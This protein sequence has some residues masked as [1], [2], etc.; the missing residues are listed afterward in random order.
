MLVHVTLWTDEAVPTLAFN[1]YL[2]GFDVQSINLRDI[3]DGD[4]PQTASAGQDPTDRISPKGPFSQDI[5]FASCRPAQIP[6]PNDPNSFIRDPNDFLSLPPL[7]LPPATLT[8]LRN[9]HTGKAS[10]LFAGKCVGLSHPGNIARGYITA[11]TVNNCTQRV[12]SDIG[13]IQPFG[14]GDVTNQNTLWGDFMFLD[15]SKNLAQGGTLAH[16]EAS[17]FDPLTIYDPNSIKYTFYGRYVDGTA[18]DNREPLATTS[19]AGY[20]SGRTDLLVWRDS[21]HVGV[22]F[23][24]GSPP[25]GLD[26]TEIVT[27]DW[28]E[29]YQRF[30]G[31]SPFPAAAQRVTVGGAAFPVPEKLGWAYLNLNTSTGDGLFDPFKQSFVTALHRLDPGTFHSG[32][33]AAQIDNASAPNTIIVAP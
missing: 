29:D 22:P 4:L 2:T 24:C 14:G 6:D 15:P 28:Q 1:V 20:L 19:T 27:F 11:D 33:P 8:A 25:A 13:Y 7:P 21:G 30:D 9:A 10:S 26:L 3:F 16:I 5:N 32:V 18:A 17:F 31:P 12:P 23:T